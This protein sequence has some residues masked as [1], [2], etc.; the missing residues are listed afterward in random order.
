MWALKLLRSKCSTWIVLPAPDGGRHGCV[1]HAGNVI[2]HARA[3]LQLAVGWNVE[4]VIR[5]ELHV[6]GL[7]VQYATERHFYLPFLW[8]TRLSA[9]DVRLFQSEGIDSAA[10]RQ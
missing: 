4:N 7:A 8:V 5:G 3:G 1:A 6:P 9:V 10:Q 2:Q